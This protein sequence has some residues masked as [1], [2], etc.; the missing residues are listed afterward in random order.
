MKKSF[1]KKT[2]AVTL[3]AM[4]IAS[5]LTGCGGSSSSEAESAG[6]LN[7]YIWTEYVPES[8]IQGF[9]DE[10]GITVNVSYY[11]SNE[12]LYAKLKSETAGTY[13]V[14]QPSDYMV[15]KMA[16]QG[17]LEEI[18]KDALSNL[19]NIA[20]EYMDPS[21]DVGNLYSI[22]YMGGIAAI[23]VN[24]A[25]VTE[26]I[27]S[28]DD[29]FSTALAGEEVFLDDSR[30]IIGLTAKSLGYSMSTTDT[31]ELDE[32]AAKL[33]TLKDNVKVYDSDSPKSV[34]ISGDCSVGMIWN[35]EI[36][37]AMEENPDIE[38]VFPEEGAY[39]FLDNWSIPTG[40]VNVTEAE[41]FIDYMLSAEASA[42]CSEELPYLNPNTA[43]CELLGDE[44]MNNEAKN[45]PA[46]EIAKGEYIQNLDTETQA[47]YEAMWTELKK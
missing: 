7:L 29:L 8:V 45:I 21:Y 15:E 28:Y 39:L 46:A 38:I 3:A 6:T 17:M 31:A 36:A 19:G 34:L 43:A 44:Y 42:A 13:D 10:T 27:T 33:L 32:I 23:A 40:A 1:I 26:E 16:E 37:M 47:I 22:P 12:D 30:A 20:A 18:N 24:T 35:A 14:I 9:E 5:M 4:S 41:M 25:T 11:S 2:L